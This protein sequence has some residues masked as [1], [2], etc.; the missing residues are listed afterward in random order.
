M[1]CTCRWNASQH[2]VKPY[3]GSESRF[4]PTPP[5]F[6]APV[7]GFRRNIAMPFGVEKLEWCGY[8]M[9]KNFLKICLFVL[10]ECTNVTDTQTH[11]VWQHRLRLHSIARQKHPD[12]LLYFWHIIGSWAH[13]THLG[14]VE[15]EVTGVCYP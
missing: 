15:C 6:D 2:A 1:Y 14:I 8:P 9:V 12:W 3:I 10:S 11:I 7:R 4:L 5:A 13:L